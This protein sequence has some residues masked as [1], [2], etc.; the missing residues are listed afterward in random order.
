[1]LEEPPPEALNSTDEAPEAAE[2][3]AFPAELPTTTK[4]LPPPFELPPPAELSTTTKL[5]PP[6]EL[7]PPAEPPPPEEL[8][9]TTSLLPPAE[10]PAAAAEPPPLEDTAA[11]EEEEEEEDPIVVILMP[12]DPLELAVFELLDVI[13]TELL[14]PPEADFP[15]DAPALTGI[16]L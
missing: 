3:A 15:L 13:K 9:T 11:V 1:M 2:L 12:P 8:P 10:L 5:L 7:P 16:S 4:L 6:P 14:V